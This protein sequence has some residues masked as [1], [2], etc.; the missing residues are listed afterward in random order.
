MAGTAMAAAGAALGAAGPPENLR[1]EYLTNP[2]GIDTPQP[3]LSWEVNDSRR[4]AMQSAYQIVVTSGEETIWDSGRV[5]SDRSIQVPYAGKALVSGQACQWRLRTWDGP[6]EASPWSEPATWSMGLLEPSDWK[7]KWIGAPAEPP[8]SDEA[9]PDPE[10]RP[11]PARMLRRAFDVPGEVRRATAYICGL[12]YYELYVN[13]RRIGDHVLDPVLTDYSRRCLYVTYDVTPEVRAGENAV[14]VILGNGRYYAPRDKAPITTT[15]YGLPVLRFQLDLEM[16]DGSTQQLVSDESWKLTTNGP[17]RANND[18]DGE[19]YDARLEM[20]GWAVAGFDDK[21]WHPAQVL[22]AP[23][24]R[25]AAQMMPPHRVTESMRPVHMDQPQPGVYVFDSG[26]NLVGWVRLTVQG[27]RGNTVALRHAETLHPDGT[28]SVENMRSARVT[29]TYVL[30]G[31]GVETY[32]PR[33]TYHGFRYVELTGFPGRP[34]LDTLTARAVHTD[35]ERIGSFTCSDELLNQIHRNIVWGVRGNLRSIPTDCPQRDERQGWLGDIATQ[36]KAEMY[37]FAVAPLFRKW[38]IDI[39]DAQNEEGIIPDVAPPFWPLYSGNVTWPAAYVIIPGWLHTLH[40]DRQVLQQHYPSLKRWMAFLAQHVEDGILSRDTYGDWCVPPESPELIHSKDPAR[41]T[42]GPLLAT[43][44]YYDNLQRMARYARLL[45]EADDAASFAKQAEA[46]KAAFHNRFFDAEKKQYDNGTQTSSVLPLAFGLAPEADAP[47][48]F[49][50]LVRSIEEENSRHI[51]TGLIGGQWL[52]RVLSD[53]GR[54]D[55]AFTLATQRTY[56]S[57]GYMVDHGATT[58]WELWNGDTADPAMNSGNHLMLV[59]DLAIWMYEYL[60]GIRPDEDHPAFKHFEIRPVPVQQLSWV[61]AQTRS[62]H[63]L[64]R[65]AWRRTNG[66]FCLD[67]T[68]PANTTATVVVPVS[69]PKKATVSE[70]GQV[71]LRDGQAAEPVPG[72]KCELVGP[73]GAVFEVGAGQYR[74][75]SQAG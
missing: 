20:N 51:A 15:T 61:R 56:P 40:D 4:G 19:V 22:D 59:G 49:A 30:R 50:R 41:K 72:V 62:P 26:Q 7:G 27:E 57:W 67:V 65:S 48:V 75:V 44:Y 11:L 31:D 5:E 55:L 68:I 73:E 47:A 8:A 1:C 2:L 74:F 33:F 60:G 69:D 9:K 10:A 43:A 39:A 52:M 25:P 53:H 38:L 71:L 21:Q 17:I 29:D 37:D 46:V 24:G 35:V 32:E 13:G 28:L 23:A 14:G 45:G 70:S 16:A 64:I 6:G 3:R 66:E 34:T 18:Y 63:G 42:A 58:V 54:A 12:G 36:S